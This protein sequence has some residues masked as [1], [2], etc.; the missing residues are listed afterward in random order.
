MTKRILLLLVV[1]A[2]N[3]T[4]E[5]MNTGPTG[6][7]GASGIVGIDPPTG[8][9]MCAAADL[10]G[11]TTTAM[12]SIN[13]VAVGAAC[14]KDYECWVGQMCVSGMCA[15]QSADDKLHGEVMTGTAGDYM[16]SVYV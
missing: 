13:P 5:P 12:A 8:P 15:A 4:T 3:K 16:V 9:K 10:A 11:I 14:T 7:T 1:A 6:T 2:C